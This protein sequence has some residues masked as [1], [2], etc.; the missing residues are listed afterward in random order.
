MIPSSDIRHTDLTGRFPVTGKSGKQGMGGVATGMGM[1]AGATFAAAKAFDFLKGS[2]NTTNEL[3]LASLKLQTITKMDSTSAGEWVLMAKGRGLG[4]KQLNTAF[5]TL[6]KNMSGATH[7]SKTQAAAFKQLG[8]SQDALRKGNPHQ[9]MLQVAEGLSHVKSGADK[10]KLSQQLF[11]RGSQGLIGVMSGG[12]KAL[13]A[14]L[15][16]YKQNAIELH[17]NEAAAKKLAATKRD[18]KNA[19]DSVKISLGTAL[20]PVIAAATKVL[21]G[22]SN[23]SPGVKKLI[24][25]LVGLAA[26]AVGINKLV[27]AFKAVKAIFM[28]LKV[29]MMTNPIGIILTLIAVAAYL[30]ITNWKSVKK[31]LMATWNW[32][33]EAFHKV[34]TFVISMAKQGFLGPVAWIITHWKQVKT[35]LGTTWAWVKE[36]FHKVAQF[37]IKMAKEGFL[38]PVAWIITH[39]KQV[40]TFLGNLVGSIKKTASDIGNALW[41]GIKSGADSVIGFAKGII[42]GVLGGLENFVNHAIDGL[43]IAIGLANE[44]P[45]VNIDKIGHISIPRVATG[46][47]VNGAQIA[48]IGEDGPEAVIPLSKKYRA[49]GSALYA[50]AGAAM[51]MGGTGGNTFNIYNTGSLDENALAARIAWQLQTRSG[52]A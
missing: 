36:A 21:T 31:F 9:V 22:F 38:G 52:L 49:Q 11:G 13:E 37:I 34:A 4:A 29:A 17:K 18:L 19:L 26:A 10:A 35:F 45:T 32:I 23:L 3:T 41:G 14:S 43:N 42:N 30:I 47:I 28:V 39:W 6:S 48:M 2:V 16:K 46:A 33:K 25:T 8:V 44:L 12:R 5:I 27:N 40:K 1:A 20:T 7:G 15:G 24:L 50:Q 51:G